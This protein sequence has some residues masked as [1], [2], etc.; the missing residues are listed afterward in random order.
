MEKN[1]QQAVQE[2]F[3]SIVRDN[4]VD[5]GRLDEPLQEELISAVIESIKQKNQFAAK[6]NRSCLPFKSRKMQRPFEK[7][8]QC[9]LTEKS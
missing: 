3:D 2:A 8:F 6:L 5:F 7:T 1:S 4:L 9:R